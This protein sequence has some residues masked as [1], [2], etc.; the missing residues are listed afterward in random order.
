MRADFVSNKSF[1][2]LHVVYTIDVNLLFIGIGI[3]NQRVIGCQISLVL[4]KNISLCSSCPIIISPV[5]CRDIRLIFLML[6]LSGNVLYINN[7]SLTI[8]IKFAVGVEVG[9]MNS[10][11]RVSR[12]LPSNVKLL[13]TNG[14]YPKI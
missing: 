1:A 12:L 13:I 6:S 9:N 14:L 5:G 8:F 11:S 3:N 10:F 4:I 2:E 7:E